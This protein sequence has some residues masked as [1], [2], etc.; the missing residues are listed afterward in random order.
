MPNR[1]KHFFVQV[2]VVPNYVY[3]RCPTAKKTFP[4]SA[5]PYRKNQCCKNQCC[6]NPCRKKSYVSYVYDKAR[7]QQ[8]QPAADMTSMAS[9]MM[10]MMQNMQQQQQPGRPNIVIAPTA[11]GLRRAGSGSLEGSG[12]L[13]ALADGPAEAAEAKEGE[14]P[15][16]EEEEDVGPG[17]RLS[18]GVASAEIEKAIEAGK[19]TKRK[20]Q[21]A[22]A[23]VPPTQTVPGMP[24]KGEQVT[25]RAAVIT[26]KDAQ[27]KFRLFLS[28]KHRGG[29]DVD[30]SWKTSS[31]SEA[32]K[33]AIERI[34][35][36][37][38]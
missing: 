3:L 24:K 1:K 4:K 35:T 19:S 30:R 15:K 28:A 20:R 38:A 6:E 13:A 5:V 33:K 10:M 16:E 31:K 17:I 18:V 26:A 29:L 22:L 34:D 25:Y 8:Q 2:Q 23:E 27:S 37:W 9:M 11:G 32:F 7:S 36:F 21:A 14:A 12:S